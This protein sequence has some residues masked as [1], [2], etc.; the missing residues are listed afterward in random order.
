M[1][2]TL[3]VSIKRA[4]EW[5]SSCLLTSLWLWL[6]LWL[7]IYR[8]WRVVVFNFGWF[9][10]CLLLSLWLL[11]LESTTG[12]VITLLQFTGKTQSRQLRFTLNAHLRVDH[13]SLLQFKAK[14]G[15][16]GWL[17]LF[18]WEATTRKRNAVIARTHISN[19]H[20]LHRCTLYTVHIGYIGVQY[21]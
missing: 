18:M 13:I 15:F 10:S 4:G 16:S 19:V 5:F 14:V 2:E 11:I 9:S 21:V 8:P 1:A 20:M 7:L 12:N 17:W 6:W 3:R